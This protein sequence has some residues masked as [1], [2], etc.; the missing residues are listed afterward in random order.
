MLLTIHQVNGVKNSYLSLEGTIL[1]FHE[2]K[3]YRRFIQS[4]LQ[5]PVE[6]ISV[7]EISRF[8]GSYLIMSLLS[9]SVPLLTTAIL[10]GIVFD[11]MKVDY[12]S[13]YGDLFAVTTLILFL[14]G[15]VMFLVFLIKFIIKRKT[16]CLVIAPNGTTIEF[17]KESKNSRE[18]DELLIQIDQRKTIVKEN[19]TQPAKEFLGFVE[20]R[21]NL[22]KFF[23]LTWLFSLPAVITRKLSLTYL[24]LLP[25]VWLLYKEIT[26]KRQPKE[27]REA[28]KS[29]FNKEWEKS[30][31]LL[32][33]L[34]KRLPTYI[35]AYIL[36]VTVYTRTH[37]FDK[38]L[39][40]TFKLPDEYLDVAQD[41][42]KNVWLF[43]RM[44]ERR[45][46]NAQEL[47]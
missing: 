16:V 25:V 43:K 22:P 19:F 35:P 33:S 18:V 38:A 39:E 32:K 15:L 11:V 2:Q 6:L 26:F 7:Y 47:D 10:Y 45:K 5:I 40:V 23:F 4:E 34:Q 12:E 14:L 36:L 21:C 31:H 44:F 9:L 41:V 29:Y 37:R 20:E 8:K 27:Y 30:I 3:G 42:Q 28:L 24:M 46:E 1:I 13:I 17:W